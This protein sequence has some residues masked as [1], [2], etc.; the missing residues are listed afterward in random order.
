MELYELKKTTSVLIPNYG[1]VWIKKNDVCSYPKLWSCM[2]KK[3]RRLFLW[4]VYLQQSAAH[5]D[6]DWEAEGGRT[7]PHGCHYTLTPWT[8]NASAD[9]E[10]HGGPQPPSHGCH[11]TQGQGQVT[12][13]LIE[14][15][16]TP[17]HGCHYTLT[18]WTG[19][20][21]AD[22]EGPHTVSWMPLHSHHLDR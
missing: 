20:T 21:S 5:T 10:A 15:G 12:R 13:Q 16:L 9:R 3:K 22:R 19:N 11:Y 18:T 7:P 8:G 17:S 2:N 14:K 4:F 6:A 1:V